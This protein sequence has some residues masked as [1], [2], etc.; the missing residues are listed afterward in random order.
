MATLLWKLSAT[1]GCTA[2]SI[3]ALAFGRVQ[4]HGLRTFFLPPTVVTILR[5]LF[6]KDHNSSNSRGDGALRAGGAACLKLEAGLPL[7]LATVAAP[8]S[9]V[10]TGSVGRGNHAAEAT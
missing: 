3:T 10:V 1:W 9:A 6:S 8:L 7:R 4:H 5:V 2:C